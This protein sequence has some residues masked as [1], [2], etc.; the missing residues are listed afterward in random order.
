MTVVIRTKRTVVRGIRLQ[1]DV[2]PSIRGDR[3]ADVGAQPAYV[4][5]A[6]PHRPVRFDGTVPVG[7]LDVDR[8]EADAAALRVFHQRRRMIEPHRLVVQEPGVER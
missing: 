1:P 2:L 3:L 4:P 5:Q 8:L 7:Q 6:E